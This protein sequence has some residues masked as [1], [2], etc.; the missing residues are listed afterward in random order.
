MKCPAC[1]HNMIVIE[2]DQIELDY[3]TSCCGIWFDKD[4][5]GLLLGSASAD[6]INRL[7]NSRE[8]RTAEKKRKCPTCGKKMKKTKLESSDV[9]FDLCP[10][11]GGI[12]FDGGEI[13]HF[14][15]QLPE[16][17][18]GARIVSFIQNTV[19]SACR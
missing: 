3:C 17:T 12:W 6:T 10:N 13:N 15:Q 18:S 14:T 19:K 11:G 16:N 8:V 7:L 9:L 2:Y 1:N 5:I 4:E